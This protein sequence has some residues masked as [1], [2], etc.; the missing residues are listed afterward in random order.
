MSATAHAVGVRRTSAL[1]RLARAAARAPMP[2]RALVASRLIVVGAGIA[3]SLMVPRRVGWWRVA[4]PTRLTERLGA[5][6]NVLAAPSVRWD[7]IHYLGIAEHGYTSA[8]SVVFFP[9]YPM[10]VRLF[11]FLL[12]SDPLAGVLISLVSVAVALMLLHRL[13]A[14]ELGPRAADAAVLLLAFA[15]LSFFFSAVYTESLFL[16]LSVGS[17][18]A[19]RQGRWKLAC[20]LGCLASATRVTGVGLFGP[21]TIMYLRERRDLD[22]RFAW[23]LTVPA[24]LVAFLGYVA[25]KGYGFLSPFAGQTGAD[26]G[27]QMTGPL[28]TLVSAVQAAAAGAH[29]ILSQPVYQPS[30]GGPLSDGAESIMLLGVLG[31]AVAVLVLVVRRLPIEYGAYALATLLVCIWSPVAGQ[32]LKSLDRYV[33]T[34]FPLWMA[35]GAWV[36]ERRLV[37]PLVLVSAAMLAF[38]TFQFATWAWVA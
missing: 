29:S 8:S 13:T 5:I 20:G 35:A 17:I 6:G 2:V 16:A 18:Y 15:P 31:L 7:S 12:G 19:A 26:H 3:G 21:L 28:Q 37:R 23:L 24:G 32:P 22:R 33:L 36:S 14:L 1:G 9:F 30:L 10:L 27:H 11:G 34:I 4:D 25:L 38:W